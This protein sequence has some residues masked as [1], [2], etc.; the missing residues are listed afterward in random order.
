MAVP[1]EAVVDGDEREAV[2]HL[3]G[4]LPTGH[5][6]CVGRLLLIEGI[7]GSG[8][9]TTAR[10]AAARLARA[11]ARVAVYCEGDPQP[12]DLAWQWWLAPAEFE[13]VCQ[14][15]AG[16]QAELRRY[17]W[18]GAAGVAVAYTKVDAARCGGQWPEVQAAMPGREPFNGSVPA[19]RFMDILAARWAEFGAS[20]GNSDSAD[21]VVFD[22]AFLQNTLVELVLFADRDADE[23]AGD[24]RRL[25]ES[26]ARW[27]PLLVRLI[28]VDPAAA[29]E[30]VAR[31]RVDAEGR[32][33]WRNAVEAYTADTPW[34][35]ARGLSSPGALQAYLS[36][37]QRLEV[38]V[39]PRLPL[40]WVDLAS[41]VGTA[42]PW[43]PFEEQLAAA[44][45]GLVRSGP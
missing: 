36:Y 40:E 38:E 15:H 14:A 35:R 9:T 19:A 22:G 39:L 42:A 37:R 16:A 20:G 28:P 21:V 26:V 32:S 11:D 1:G 23:I 30:S 41:P 13:A 4:E 43:G 8:K 10:S 29:L 18:V 5:D 24:L 45:A 17:A 44:L 34:A 2:D 12:A 31:E 7:P 27:R 25:A 3:D 6:G 33:Q